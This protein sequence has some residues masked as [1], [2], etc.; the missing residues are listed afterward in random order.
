VRRAGE[1]ASG[2]GPERR[3][4][5]STRKRSDGSVATAGVSWRTAINS[6]SVETLPNVGGVKGVVTSQPGA[7]LKLWTLLRSNHHQRTERS[8]PI[9]A[10]SDSISA[11]NLR[12]PKSGRRNSGCPSAAPWQGPA[13]KEDRCASPTESTDTHE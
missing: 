8:S 1:N 11:P 9:L 3:L 6:G 7:N 2:R 10:C 4:P 5:E 13:S 12:P